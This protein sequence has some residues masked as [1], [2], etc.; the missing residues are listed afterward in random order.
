MH[1]ALKHSPS[2]VHQANG[3]SRSA[4]DRKTFSDTLAAAVTIEKEV[5]GI[6][7]QSIAALTANN[8]E[9]S[10]AVAVLIKAIA[11]VYCW[12]ADDKTIATDGIILHVA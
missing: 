5:L 1:G 12:L 10:A 9:F 8:A 6:L 2:S 4:N 11:N 7:V 3:P